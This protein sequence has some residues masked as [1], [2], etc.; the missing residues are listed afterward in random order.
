MTKG[1][2]RQARWFNDS[3]ARPLT[4]GWPRRNVPF[5]HPYRSLE[6]IGNVASLHADGAKTTRCKTPRRSM[7]PMQQQ[8]RKVPAI[9]SASSLT[10]RVCFHVTYSLDTKCRPRSA[11]AMARA[12]SRQML[13]G[14]SRTLRTRPGGIAQHLSPWASALNSLSWAGSWRSRSRVQTESG[15]KSRF[16]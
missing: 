15:Q 14:A 10:S 1:V 3:G 4:C 6:E 13:M 9:Q 8:T 11:R 2:A 7:P 12:E 16:R 5:G